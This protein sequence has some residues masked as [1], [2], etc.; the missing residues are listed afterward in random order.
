[1][2][3]STVVPRAASSGDRLPHLAPPGRVEPAPHAT[4]EGLRRPARHL[5]EAELLEQLVGAP[6]GGRPAD[7]EEPSE[8]DQVVPGGDDVVD[9]G[10]L[11]DHADPAPHQPR[12]PGHVVAGHLRP[13]GYAVRRSK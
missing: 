9:G 12:L 5:G 13:A 3:S 8:Q 11:A 10:L 7:V 6:P 4:G 2:V 1:V